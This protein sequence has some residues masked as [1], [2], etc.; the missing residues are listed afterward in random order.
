[1]TGRHQGLVT[2][3]DEA[4]VGNIYQ[5]WCGEHQLDLLIQ[6]IFGKLLHKSFMTTTQRLSGYLQCQQTLICQMRTKYPRFIDTRWLSMGLSLTWLIANHL[7]VQEYLDLKNPDC[8]PQKD[9]W[10]MVFC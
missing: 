2:Q 5:V 4:A 9:W 8:K 6:T 1:M 7:S 3:L 10:V